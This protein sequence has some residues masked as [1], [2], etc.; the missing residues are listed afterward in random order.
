MPLPA[1][2][3]PGRTFRST[4][5]KPGSN[6]SRCCRVTIWRRAAVENESVGRVENY[7][8]HPKDAHS[9][10]SWSATGVFVMSAYHKN[11][12][13]KASTFLL[14][15]H[16]GRKRRLISTEPHFQS[17]QAADLSRGVSNVSLLLLLLVLHELTQP[18]DT[19]AVLVASWLRKRTM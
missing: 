9:P 15:S 10:D 8:Q 5:G 6:F 4:W 13:V 17:Q 19:D 2:H 14:S 16:I 12:S 3:P 1:S 7:A 11:T 18:R